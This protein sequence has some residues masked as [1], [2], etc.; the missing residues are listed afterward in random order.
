MHKWIAG[1][2][3]LLIS[4][5]VAYAGLVG[6]HQT[7]GAAPYP[8]P[9]DAARVETM[10]APVP[11]S[12]KGPV[13]AQV[14]EDQGIRLYYKDSYP[15]A[16]DDLNVCEARGQASARLHFF[17]AKAYL[18]L[19]D[20]R[21]AVK[22]FNTSLAANPNDEKALIGRAM[23]YYKMGELANASEDVLSVMRTTDDGWTLS[24]A[25]RLRA[26]ILQN[27][28]R[29][30]LAWESF[31]RAYES[32]PRFRIMAGYMNPREL[33]MFG[34]LVLI[35]FPIGLALNIRLKPPKKKR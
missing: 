16:I 15:Q 21:A 33:R 9:G 2:A 25:L 14:C 8:A 30:D 17:R 27:E 22:D 18:A 6:E 3:I 11:A 4:I 32:D 28:G 5:G 26:N 20:L 24:Q 31:Q 23:A 10:T 34:L 19:D 29:E 35:A 13:A 7:E 1:T 12:E